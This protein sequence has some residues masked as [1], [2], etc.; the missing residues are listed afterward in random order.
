[1][2]RVVWS[3]VLAAVLALAAIVLA[4]LGLAEVALA[5]GLASVSAA[6]LSNR[7]K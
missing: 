4:V 7:E 6:V 2:R 3:A 1:M 5:C